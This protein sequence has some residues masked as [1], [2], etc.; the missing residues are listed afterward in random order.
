MKANPLKYY[1]VEDNQGNIRPVK[2]VVEGKSFYYAAEA[3]FID[4]S[5]LKGKEGNK[6]EFYVQ[7][8]KRSEHRLLGVIE[9][10]NKIVGFTFEDLE[11][12]N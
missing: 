1:Y 11:E 12:A 10:K 8:R 2:L 5:P 9:E 3:D 7:G 6:I 4:F